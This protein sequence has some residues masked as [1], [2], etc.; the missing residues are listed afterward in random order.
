MKKIVNFCPTGS[1]TTRENSLAPLFPNEIIEEVCRAYDEDLITLVHVHARDENGKPS[2]KVEH[3]APIVEGLRKYCPD[4]AICTSLSGRYNNTIE[5]RT[6]VLSL[7]PDMGSLTMG[8]W[9]YKTGVNINTPPMI[10]GLIEKMKEYNVIP[11]IECFD[12]GMLNYANHLINKKILVEPF[13]INM[14]FGNIS[15]AQCDIKTIYYILENKHSDAVMCFGGIGKQQFAAI[16]NGLSLANGVRVG[17]ED[18]FYS[19][20]G[21]KATNYYLLNKVKSKKVE[22]MKP[23]EFKNFLK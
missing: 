1:E 13:Y 11:E 5:A 6:E 10:L 3:F 21:E 20:N 15:N 4:L 23:I 9:N 14:I 18:N 22:I 17:L 8:S 19:E 2:N 16:D 12:S 7:K